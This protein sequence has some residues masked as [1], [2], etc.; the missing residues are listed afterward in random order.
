MKDSLLSKL[1]IIAERHEELAALLSD[2]EIVSDQ[3][4]FRSFS[5]EYAEI[6]PIVNAFQSY[7]GAKQQLADAQLLLE[8]DDPEM[9]DLAADDVAQ[10]FIDLALAKKTTGAVMTVDGGNIAATLR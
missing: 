8:D 9:R 2:A 6:E 10:T 1:S 4:K 7:N 3:Q 5:Q